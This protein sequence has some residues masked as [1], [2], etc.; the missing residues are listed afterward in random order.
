MGALPNVRGPRFGALAAA[1]LLSGCNWG[2]VPG[3]V[4]QSDSDCRPGAKCDLGY[5]L[6]YA[7]AV[8]AGIGSDAGAQDAGPAIDAG[9]PVFVVTIAPSSHDG[10]IDDDPQMPGAWHRD[11]FAVIQVSSS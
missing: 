8:D 1:V 11:E 7:P 5:H 2:P 3:S 9:P 10:G 4:C 6:C